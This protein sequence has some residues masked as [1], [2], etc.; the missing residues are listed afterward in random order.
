MD[1]GAREQLD[2][3]FSSPSSLLG[4]MASSASGG[5]LHLRAVLGSRFELHSHNA[6]VVVWAV[7][8]GVRGHEIG[9]TETRSEVGQVVNVTWNLPIAVDLR[10]NPNPQ[11]EFVVYDKG[12]K[13]AGGDDMYFQPTRFNFQDVLNAPAR[14]IMLN[15]NLSQQ[16]SLARNSVL[17]IS[18]GVASNVDLS[19]KLSLQLAASELQGK[20]PGCCGG[21]LSDTWIK[22][23]RMNQNGQKA[24]V[25]T[26]PVVKGSMDPVWEAVPTMSLSSFTFDDL[27]FPSFFV[28]VWEAG[29]FSENLI[30]LWSGS[31]TDVSAA[32]GQP[33]GITLIDGAISKIAQ[34]I[35][36][37]EILVK[38]CELLS[39]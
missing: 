31:F 25:W 15:N 24:L 23:F 39:S 5:K 14:T 10:S 6:Y 20:G 8:N 9:R 2:V 19:S 30:G 18:A 29:M 12:G 33:R 21:G 28:E 34:R 37:G 22:I 17:T 32:A 1:C 7:V 3:F 16:S 27:T 36:R 26:S 11:L 35:P 4:P 13:F 38:R